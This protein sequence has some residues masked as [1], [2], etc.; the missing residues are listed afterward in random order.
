MKTIPKAHG[1]VRQFGAE[2]KVIITFARKPS[3]E[4]MT[5][6]RKLIDQAAKEIICKHTM[7][8]YGNTH[9]CRDCGAF[10]P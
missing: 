1:V 2:N 3:D 4:E 6:L 7:G 5:S 9:I 8:P 10:I